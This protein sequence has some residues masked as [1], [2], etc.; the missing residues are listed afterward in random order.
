M[1]VD[2]IV[3]E[4]HIEIPM[5]DGVIL[6]A[7]LYR[8]ADADQPGGAVPGIVTRTPYDKEQSG[9]GI[10]AVMPSP[11]KLAE[12]G[13][14][15]VVCDCRGRYASE[16][17]FKP[18]HQEGPDGYDTLEWVAS[19]PWCDGSTAIFGPSYVGATTMLAARERP[20]SL[21]CAIPIITAD[22]YFDGWTYQGGAFQ[23]GF[24]GLWGS[25]LAATGYLQ[26]DHQRPVDA[27]ASVTEALMGN[28]FQLLGSRP[29]S[30][31]P[32]ISAEGVAP[33]W[34]EW[35][36]HE[37][38]DEYWEAIRHSA[39]YSRFQ[40]PMLHVGGWF[41]I[42]GIG[43]VR[44]FRGIRAEGNPEQHLIMGPWAHTNYDRW[45]GEL[46]FGPTG[47]AATANVI[48]D[49]NVFLDRHLKGRDRE[50]PAVRWFLMGAN[51][52]RAHDSWPPPTAEERML[53]LASDGGATMHYSDG[54]LVAECPAEDHRWDEFLYT[55]YK[56]VITEG[57]STLQQGIGLPGPRDQSRTE[58]RDDVLCY[59]T[60]PLTESLD[61]AG[62]VEVDLWISSSQPD[63]DFTAKLVDVHPDGKPVSLVDGIMRARFRE[64]FEREVTLTPG[65]VVSLTID[66]ASLGHRFSV[67][68]RIR[69]EV[70]SSNYPR[71]MVN[72]NDGSSVNSATEMQPAINT[73]RRGG[74]FPSA[75]RLHVLKD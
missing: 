38:R 49:I 74:E 44:N 73:I 13:Y 61:V 57:G 31:M 70:S 20:P 68:H 67:G 64:G 23:L 28:A 59:S 12:R 45:L 14:A 65:E 43:T 9:G 71:F 26:H 3:V 34:H 56:P 19:Q 21:R 11:L 63:T 75:L 17:E 25:G 40:V 18:F 46:E 66:L 8:P 7:D 2:R 69:L 16:G 55:G 15:V 39:D 60:E 36:E 32:G 24:V 33:Y 48:A 51:E 54:R 52:W 35:L 4:K 6:R 37:S 5:R 72:S 29:L 27:Q 50:L 41:D 22:D 58:S 62:P 10:V 47:A 42:F 1:G 53:Y 30:N